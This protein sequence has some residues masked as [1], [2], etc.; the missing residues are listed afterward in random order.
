MYL[1]ADMVAKVYS[2]VPGATIQ[3]DGLTYVFPC[4]GV[5]GT[6]GSYS[7]F[8]HR[9]ELMPLLADNLIDVWKSDLLY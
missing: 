5:N 2:K 9:I 6:V 1:P 4:A 7:S 3:P 8:G